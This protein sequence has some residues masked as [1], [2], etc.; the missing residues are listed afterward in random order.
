MTT[1][2]AN[3][4]KACQAPADHNIL[5]FRNGKSVYILRIPFHSEGRFANVTNV[6]MGCGGRGGARDGRGQGGRR[7]RVVLTA[8]G[9]ASSRRATAGDGDK[10]ILIAGESAK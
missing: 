9:L 7:S 10:Q 3:H 1:R 2:R 8:S 6:G 4:P 5:I